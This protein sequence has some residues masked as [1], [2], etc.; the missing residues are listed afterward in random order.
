M[1]WYNRE[2]CVV[3]F[4]MGDITTLPFPPASLGSCLP[5]ILQHLWAR[6]YPS[7]SNTSVDG[8]PSRTS[9]WRRPCWKINRD[10]PSNG[11]RL[12]HGLRP[13]MSRAQRPNNAVVPCWHILGEGRTCHIISPEVEEK[14][15]ESL[16]AQCPCGWVWLRGQN[17]S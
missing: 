14:P 5:F 3:I 4:K 1:R 11:T 15:C 12:G 13:K 9:R 16:W 7:S 2:N 17:S 8:K 6:A 10:I